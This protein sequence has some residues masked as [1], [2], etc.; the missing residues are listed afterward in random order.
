LSSVLAW[1]RPVPRAWPDH[2]LQAAPE[3][4]R[5]QRAAGANSNVVVT[6][7][8]SRPRVGAALSGL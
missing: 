5:R 8:L 2:L 1:L 4:I 6:A 3:D 7:W